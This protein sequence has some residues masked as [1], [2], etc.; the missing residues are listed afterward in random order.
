VVF[1]WPDPGVKADD[2]YVVT[3][4]GGASSIQRRTEF[5]VDAQG[6]NRVCLTVSVNREGKTGASSS[7]KC[8]DVAARG[9]Q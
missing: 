5:T 1:A 8:V 3:V 7:E 4:P 2:T 9:P 6:A